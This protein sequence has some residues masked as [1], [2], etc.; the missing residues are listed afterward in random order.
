MKMGSLLFLICCLLLARAASVAEFI[1]DEA[2]IYLDLY[3]VDGS[4]SPLGNKSPEPFAHVLDRDENR[5]KALRYRI[6]SAKARKPGVVLNQSIDILGPESVSIPVN[7]G[8]SV[9]SGNYYAKI[10][11]GVPAKYYAM[12]LDTGSSLSWLQCQPCAI[13][14]HTQVDALYNPSTSSKYKSLPCSSSQCSSLKEATLNDPSCEV[15]TGKCVYTASYGDSSY[16]MGY[17]SQDSLS[18]SPSETLPN[19][20]YGCGQDNE[21]LFGRAA[22]IV[23][24]ARQSLSMISQLSSKYGNAFSYCL[25]SET[26]TGNGFLSL[27]RTSLTAS[28]FRFTPMITESRERSLYFLRLGAISLAGKPLAVAAM[29]YR[30]PTI[31]DSGTV[32]SRLPSSVYAALRQA[33]TK[34]MSTKYAKAPGYSI[35]DTCFKGSLKTMSVPQMRLVFQGGAD[36]ALTPANILI[37]V[38]K[39]TTCLAFTSSSGDMEIAII[40]NHQQ[41][42]FTVAYDV[43]N[44]RIGFAADGCH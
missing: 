42:T 34:I 4:N 29:Q 40:G 20:L 2:A 22:G 16:S 30:V 31:I 14:C 11:L 43:T 35:L 12:L 38:E 3:H 23:G 36:L 25:P 9:G 28:A 15:R 37:D 17:L 10:G 5:I 33:F 44:S 39:G 27:G 41:K 8:L 32:I 6:T 18:L 19:F 1:G 26:A 13:Y 21:G 24:L 7:S